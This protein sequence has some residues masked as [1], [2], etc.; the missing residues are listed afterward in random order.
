MDQQQAKEI[1]DAAESDGDSTNNQP[2]VDGDS[3]AS[4]GLSFGLSRKQLALIGV[5]V[6]VALL[7]KL[8]ASGNGG[9]AAD[10]IKAVAG[11]E[12]EEIETAV[13]DDGEIHVPHDPDDPLD[14][15]SAV[16]DALTERGVLTGGD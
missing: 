2:S 13:D 16:V 7:V 6:V 14:A 11:G 5:V 1:R 10:E 15:D 8:H 4:S 12:S 9:S 3:A